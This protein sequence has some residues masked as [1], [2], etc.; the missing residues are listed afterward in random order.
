MT[1]ETLDRFQLVIAPAYLSGLGYN[2]GGEWIGA[3][4]AKWLQGGSRRLIVS[5]HPSLA[6]ALGVREISPPPGVADVQGPD[7]N[8]FVAVGAEGDEQFLRSGYS[9]R[10]SWG[11]PANPAEPLSTFRWTP[12]V[13]NETSFLLPASTNR[14]H[15]L[16]V[17]GRSMWPNRLSLLV[18]GR[19]VK[20]VDIPA[21]MYGWTSRYPPA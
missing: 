11:G 8:V 17:F 13:G 15:A 3:V 5:H 6:A 20:S 12:A 14:N 10:E 18:N 19:E 21:G 9:G 2:A 1:A 4:L 7:L 16:R